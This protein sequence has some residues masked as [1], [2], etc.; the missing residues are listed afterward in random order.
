MQ[1]YRAPVERPLGRALSQHRASMQKR[2]SELAFP[3]IL[4]L[5]GVA[6]ASPLSAVPVVAGAVIVS[7]AV[8]LAARALRDG[9]R[10]LTLHEE[11]LVLVEGGKRTVVYWSDVDALGSRRF[12]ERIVVNGFTT[13]SVD[14]HTLRLR[15]G[16]TVV[17]RCAFEDNAVVD[18]RLR[19]LVARA[20]A[21][22]DSE[23]VR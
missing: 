19:E 23:L 4:V 14:V 8:N 3:V 6:F 12:A 22:R 11:A 13:S 20:A 5:I 1:A 16:D 17:I 7:I 21:A 15:S 2:A 10:D 18:E 9:R